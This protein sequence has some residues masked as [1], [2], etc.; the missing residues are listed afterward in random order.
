MTWISSHRE[1]LGY[2]V[3]IPDARGVRVGWITFDRGLEGPWRGWCAIATCHELGGD[4]TADKAAR[5]VREH[6]LRAHR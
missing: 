2:E 5:M 3:R 4:Y 1:P 6:W